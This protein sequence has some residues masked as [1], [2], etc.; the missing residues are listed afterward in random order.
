[1]KKLAQLSKLEPVLA[2]AAKAT[3]EMLV[4]IKKDQAEADK[5]KEIVSAEE[6]VVS[7]QAE[8]AEQMAAEAQ[9]ELDQVLPLLEE[10][11]TTF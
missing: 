1:M 7:K 3:E 4:K 5:M 6:K 2:S 8:E 10:A 9:K 11:S